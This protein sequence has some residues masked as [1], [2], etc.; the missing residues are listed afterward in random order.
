MGSGHRKAFGVPLVI[1][2]QILLCF[3]RSANAAPVRVACVDPGNRELRARIEGQTRDLALQMIWV[4][5]QG[6]APPG[7]TSL[8]QIAKRYGA[9]LVVALQPSAAGGS[10]VY[11]YDSAQRVLRVRQVPPPRNGDR[12]AQSTAAETAALIIRGELSA[13]LAALHEPGSE[14]SS[15]QDGPSSSEEPA[16][17]QSGEGKPVPSPGKTPQERKGPQTAQ[18][19]PQTPRDGSKKPPASPEPPEEPPPEEPPP[20]AG[21]GLPEAARPERVLTLEAGLRVSAPGAGVLL[22]GAW[23]SGRLALNRVEMGLGAS[24]TLPSDLA[25]GANRIALRRHAIAAELSALVVWGYDL[26]L[27]LGVSAGLALHHRETR[28]AD[29]ELD[30]QPAR[31]TPGFVFGPLAEARWRFAPNLG[32]S[33]RAGVDFLLQPPRFTYGQPQAPRELARLAPYEPFVSLALFANTWH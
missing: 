21:S 1:L 17:S 13:A 9:R 12:M 19:E 6:D 11:V 2:S 23:L 4:A 26:E 25:R 27:W 24:T 15:N 5:R 31:T 18:Q 3:T 10:S 30:P 22:A 32:L 14:P 29:A 16:P 20:E 7:A 28:N 8:A 33:L